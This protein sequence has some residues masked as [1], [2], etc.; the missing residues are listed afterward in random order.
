MGII[1]WLMGQRR[2][3]SP[4]PEVDTSAW[5]RRERP[6]FFD[7]IEFGDLNYSKARAFA[8]RPDVKA[9]GYEITRPTAEAREVIRAHARAESESQMK[10]AEYRRAKEEDA[11]CP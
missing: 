11:K 2:N 1:S 9:F 3:N 6:E 10:Y 5:E 4:A 7:E 8:P